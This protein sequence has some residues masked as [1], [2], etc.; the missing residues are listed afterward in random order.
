MKKSAY[1]SGFVGS[2]LKPQLSDGLLFGAQDYGQG[3]VV[4]LAD[5]VIFRLF[6][7]NGKMMLSNAVFWLASSICFKYF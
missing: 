1:I 5:D 7:E 3:Q 2:K 6:W 4:V